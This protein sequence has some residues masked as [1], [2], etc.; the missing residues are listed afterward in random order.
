MFGISIFDLAVIS[1]YVTVIVWLGWRAKRHVTTSGDYFMGNRRGSKVMMIANAIGAGTHTN[2]AIL[3]AGAT[4]QL[5]LAGIWYQWFFLFATPFFWL[6]APVYRR[7]RYVTLGD[8]FEERYGSKAATAYTIMG[9]LWFAL[10]VG[11]I[12][13]GTGTAIEAITGGQ[14]S[15]AMIVIVLTIFFL[16]YSV[17]GGFVSAL[18]VNVLQGVFVVVLSFLLIPFALKAG[19]GISAMK[20]KLPEHMFSF[21]APHEVTLFL[22]IMIV[23]NGLVGVVVEPHHMAIGGSGKS[24]INCRTGWTYGNFVKRF[25]T[26][27]WAFIGVLA[28]AL[29]PGLTS[30]NREQA[31]GLAVVN[32]LPQGLIGLMIAAMSAMVLG[33]CHNFM[34]GGSA[35]F[36]KNLYQKFASTKQS[37]KQYL[38]IGRISS[39]LIVVVGVTIALTLSSVLQG[40]KYLWQITA[41]FGI[42]FWVGLMWRRANRYGV[43]ASIMT[44]VIVAFTTGPFGLQ[45]EYQYQIALYLPVGFMIMILVSAF[46]KQEPKEKLDKFYTLLHTPVGEEYKLKE[47]GIDMMLEGESVRAYEHKA[48]C[49]SLEEE[50]HSL[51]V[52]DFLSL[53]EKFSFKKYKVDVVGFLFAALFVLAILS[54]G[55][56]LASVG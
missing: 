22:I 27:G 18:F 31:F 7:L 17:L 9:L 35:L 1:I 51:L 49:L 21:I 8:F 12:L 4:Y 46:T 24:E 10:N 36:T 38:K 44:S 33:A 23:I 45:W 39:L 32:L 11:L 30:A 6:I 52:V 37:D 48:Q 16:S 14:L 19:G 40:I 34:V 20:A 42:A 28:A 55:F 47:Q 2:Q 26:L 15:S 3:V 5:G 25:A 54:I 56:V 13:K 29:Y 50:G 41:F 53:K 43:F